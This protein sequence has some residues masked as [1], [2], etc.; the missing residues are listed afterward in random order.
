M[1][2]ISQAVFVVFVSFCLWLFLI[3]VSRRLFARL[4]RIEH[5]DVDLHPHSGHLNRAVTFLV[6]ALGL[7][8]IW[9]ID[10]N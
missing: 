6:T 4:Y 2:K 3:A 5:E 10:I 9:K 7:L 1:G 8:M